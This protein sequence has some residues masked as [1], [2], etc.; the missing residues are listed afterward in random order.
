MDAVFDPSRLSAVIG[1][2]KNMISAASIEEREMRPFGVPRDLYQPLPYLAVLMELGNESNY[3]ETNSKIKYTIPK[4][5]AD[6]EFEALTQ[7]WT[8]AVNALQAFRQ[9]R[10]QQK[11]RREVLKTAV[12]DAQVTMDCFNRYTIS[13]RGA[14]PEIYGI[15]R[16]ADIT[17]QF[18]M[19]LRT[20][21]PPPA[22]QSYLRRSMRPLKRLGF[23]SD[24]NAWMST[25]VVK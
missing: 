4:P 6:G 20:T 15:L 23:T 5:P 16:E 21:M 2:V 13:I 3:R 14:D 17:S 7:K 19:L 1:Q 12:H 11:D 10:V 24:Y 25:F 8:N 9:R 22:D 18:E